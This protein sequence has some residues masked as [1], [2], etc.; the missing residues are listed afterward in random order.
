LIGSRALGE[1][2]AFGSLRKGGDY[3]GRRFISRLF[4]YLVQR[5][6]PTIA[7][8][9]CG[10]KLIPSGFARQAAQVMTVDG[11]AFDVELLHIARLNQIPV[12]EVPVRWKDQPGSKVRVV[13]DGIQA[14]M[15]LVRIE[16]H[17]MQGHYKPLPKDPLP[18]PSKEPLE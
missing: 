16:W 6:T 2:R 17:S 11:F 13:Q 18:L 4:N 12:L 3:W 15:S 14:S 1:N 8:T 9:Q 5:L 10:F 7:D